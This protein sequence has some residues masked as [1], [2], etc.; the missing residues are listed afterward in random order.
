MYNSG[1]RKHY[2]LD[3]HGLKY[4]GKIFGLAAAIIVGTHFSLTSAEA[5]FVQGAPVAPVVQ[6]VPL[7]SPVAPL[8]TTTPIRVVNRM[9]IGSAIPASGKFIAADLV[10]ME[11]YLYQDGSSIAQYPI[12]TKGRPG[13]PYETPAG[14]YNILSKEVDHFNTDEQVHMPYSMQ[15]YGN[16]FIHGWPTYVDGSPVPTTYS[17]GCI[18]LSTA[19]AAAVYAFADRNTKVFVYDPGTA[20]TSSAPL[21]LGDVP[22]PAV[23]AHSYLVADLDTGDVYA[24]QNGQE[25]RPIASVTKLV[26]AL[27]ANETIMFDHKVEITRGNLIEP[28]KDATDTTP[29]RFVVGDLLYPLLMESNNH[30]AD[31]LAHYYGEPAF[32]GWM[33]TQAQALDMGSTTFV[34]PSGISRDDVSTPEDLYR[35]AV[36]LANKKSF[37]WKI[38]RTPEKTII[39]DDGSSY[40]FSNFNEFSNL[41][42]FVGGKVGQTVPAGDT[43]VSVFSLPFQGESR[44]IAVVVLGSNDSTGD[45]K[46]LTDW[47][48]KSAGNAPQAACIL[49]AQQPEAYK[50]IEL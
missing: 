31:T 42:S 2:S 49:C 13:T 44:R 40:A 1:V 35:L 10:H 41:P 6:H 45:T 25:E 29:V 12:L 15:F 4:T 48:T 16:Y 20:A 47:F 8:S 28:Y 50:K 18:R 24:E 9:T 23:S 19:D 30:V 38:T 22:P 3:L 43:M 39:A 46:A 27:V 26:T 33:N 34:D 37:V 7:A 17:G 21:A 32:V 5:L 14:F 11:L 36:Y